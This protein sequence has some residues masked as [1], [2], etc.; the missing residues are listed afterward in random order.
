MQE[1]KRLC[2]L[3]SEAEKSMNFEDE[4]A[5]DCLSD[6]VG[7]WNFLK[8]KAIKICVHTPMPQGGVLDL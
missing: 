4:N 1:L 7:E 5:T 2:K 8:L 6:C 3:E